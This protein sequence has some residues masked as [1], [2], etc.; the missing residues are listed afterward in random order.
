[1]RAKTLGRRSLDDYEGR[2]WT[3]LYEGKEGGDLRGMGVMGSRDV[4]KKHKAEYCERLAGD[5][6]QSVVV[7]S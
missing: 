5:F 7:D 1:M 6:H 4:V 3:G 2:D